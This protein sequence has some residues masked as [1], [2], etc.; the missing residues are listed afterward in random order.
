M[1]VEVILLAAGLGTRLKNKRPKALVTLKGKPLFLYSLSVLE[2]S[3]LISSIIIV[4]A[5]KHI[6]EFSR[7]I[8]KYKIKKVTCVVAGGKR[9]CDSVLAAVKKIDSETKFVVIHDSARPFLSLDIL[10]RVFKSA[11]KS[12]A[13]IAAMPIKSTFKKVNKKNLF[14]QE[15]LDR[16]EI[17]EVQTPQIFDKRIL[18]KAYRRLSACTTP[19]DDAALVEAMGVP[20]RVV[21]GSYSNIKITT[22]EDMCFAEKLLEYAKGC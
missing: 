21:E 14:V 7:L 13:A 18:D 19:T 10:D 1:K 12:K 11:L 4:S 6:E 5:K 15:T 17:W 2:K 22:F 20:V 8:E 16:S 3:N 9:R